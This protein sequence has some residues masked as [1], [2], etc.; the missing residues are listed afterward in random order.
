MPYLPLRQNGA[1]DSAGFVPA[2]FMRE[3]P[4]SIECV[5]R[6]SMFGGFRRMR[7]KI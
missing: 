6:I 1:A 7:R 2:F 4:R 3:K 5:C